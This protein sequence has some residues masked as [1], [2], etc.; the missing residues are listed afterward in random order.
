MIL[1]AKRAKP[2]TTSFVTTLLNVEILEKR[3]AP[4]DL[5]AMYAPILGGTLLAADQR[6][7][8]SRDE[9]LPSQIAELSAL[10]VDALYSAGPL[11]RREC[12]RVVTILNKSELRLG[13][14]RDNSICRIVSSCA[15]RGL[16]GGN[17]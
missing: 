4:D 3:N 17:L 15:A 16:L 14:R 2:S 10:R 5:V 12:F 7:A 13:A 11:S 1:R 9:S 6:F 8:Q